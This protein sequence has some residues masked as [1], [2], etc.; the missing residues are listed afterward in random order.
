MT[1]CRESTVGDGAAE[2]FYK[3]GGVNNSK[4]KEKQENKENKINPP[5]F[6]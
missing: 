1:G 5:F 6:V 2:R 3:G 4:E